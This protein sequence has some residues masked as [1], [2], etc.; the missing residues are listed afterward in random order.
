MSD[1]GLGGM[2]DDIPDMRTLAIPDGIE[3]KTYKL[4]IVCDSKE[5]RNAAYD[6]IKNSGVNY[7]EMKK[8]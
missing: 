1:F 6:A 3:E 5:D 4:T 2:T 7:V 8:T